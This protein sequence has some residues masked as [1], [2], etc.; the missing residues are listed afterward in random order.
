M[1]K[2]KQPITWIDTSDLVQ[3]WQQDLLADHAPATIRRYLAV[4]RRFLAWYEQQERLAF[5]PD[6]LT[7]IMLVGYR[8]MLHKTQTASTVNIHVCALR[9]W[10]T[11]LTERASLEVNPA[12][13]FKQV[14]RQAAHA[15]EPLTD[16]QINALLRV[17]SQS[18]HPQRDTAIVQLLL[19]TGLRIGECARLNWGDIQLGERQGQ[20]IVRAGKGN[21]TRRVPLN[22]TV[23]QA[24][25]EYTAPLLE[26]E[27]ILKRVIAAWPIPALARFQDPLWDSQKKGML[28]VSAM[29]RMIDSLVRA[30]AVRGLIPPSTSA[31][32]LRHTFARH[33]LAANPGDLAG[34]ASIL[35]HNSLNT[36]RIYVQPTTDD[37]AE[38]TERLDLNAFA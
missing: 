1:S 21:K 25:T 24:L 15:P 17:A 3:Q 35:G 33:Y 30:C 26:T 8:N 37:L 23:R 11:W 14:A 27:P 20:L 12:G 7:P 9:K 19:Q 22:G 36:T 18:R 28:S 6:D 32:T 29:Q 34:L 5:Q 16:N 38:R 13:R 2:K 10:A 4:I 31:H